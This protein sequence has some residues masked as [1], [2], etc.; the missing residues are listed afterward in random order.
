MN[1]AGLSID[2]LLVASMGQIRLEDSE[3]AACPGADSDPYCNIPNTPAGTN[4]TRSKGLARDPQVRVRR[5]LFSSGPLVW[6]RLI[7]VLL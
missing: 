7:F 1:A 3:S 4:G 6:A 2:L 5:M